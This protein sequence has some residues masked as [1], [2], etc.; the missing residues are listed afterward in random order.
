[1]NR[2]SGYFSR[3]LTTR[4][5]GDQSVISL[6]TMIAVT[7]TGYMATFY[8]AHTQ[9]PA[10]LGG[11][12][13]FM[14]YYGIFDLVAD[15]GFGG[16]VVKRI[17][18][19]L[20]KNEFFSA[21][22]ALRLALLAIAFAVLF[23]A[24][25]YLVDISSAGLFIPLILAILTGSLYSGMYAGV[26]GQGKIGITKAGELLSFFGRIVIQVGGV[27]LGYGLG[28]LLGG[29]I[30]GLLVGGIIFSRFINLTL[31]SFSARHIK[32]LLSFSFWIFLTAG[33][34]LVF[35][36]S[37]V[38]LIGYFLTNADVGIYRAALQ[39]TSVATFTTIALQSVLYPQI[40]R[41]SVEGD[42]S[43][44]QASLSRA[45]T[46]SLFLSVPVAVGG[47]ILGYPLLFYLYGADFTAGNG[48]LSILLAMQIINV[49]MYLEIMSLN[50]M[51]RPHDSFR[52]TTVAAI[53]N[54]VLNIG[55]IPVLGIIGAAIATAFSMAVN[56]LISFFLLR[57]IVPVGIERKPVGSII[58][59]AGIMG[60][61]IA[62]L[63]FLLPATNAGMLV[64][65]V[66]VG[67]GIYTVAL[68]SLDPDI[69]REIR[70]LVRSF[71]GPWP[72]WLDRYFT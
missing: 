39:L 14:A 12:F 4:A 67:T 59:S 43:R 9:G 51:N 30:V 71:G 24:R 50:A 64:A 1:M 61:G 42:I 32:S 40:S 45:F 11:Y 33:G 3:I 66:A 2:L 70:D 5:I 65:I 35:S 25:P 36:I 47:W 52:A 10:I 58:L 37:D 63:Q 6:I 13:L 8:F 41:W 72:H 46:Y 69:Y 38:I 15:G 26:Y 29:F 57:R 19:G 49:F 21:F 28:G 34:N 60:V 16:A 55:L 54:I 68:F 22:L 56:A 53:L 27:Y 23:L 20:E 7:L 18:E 17:S 62:I 44:I 48:S 31:V